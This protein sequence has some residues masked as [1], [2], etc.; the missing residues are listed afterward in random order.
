MHMHTD[1]KPVA[2]GTPDQPPAK[3]IVGGITLY[4]PQLAKLDAATA[5]GDS[6]SAVLRRLIDQ[7]L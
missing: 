6:R 1:A 7:H 3:K 4:G 2:T 5:A